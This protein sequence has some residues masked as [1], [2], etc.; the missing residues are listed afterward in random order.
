[1][2]K[3]IPFLFL[4]PILALG[5]VRLK[6]KPAA[7][8]PAADDK[9][10]IDGQTNGVRALD[11]KA[12][13]AKLGNP[14]VSGYVLS[15]TTS[16]V[17]SWVAQSGGAGTWGTITG[18]LS[19]Q[20][21]L[22]TALGLK[23]AAA[24]NLSDLADAATARGNLGLGSL[25]TQSGT[26]SGSH[27]GTSSGTNTGDQTISIT[28]DVTASGSTGALSATV[29]KIN[30][31]TLSGLGTG[32]LKN[33]TGTG[34]PSI[35]VAGD[36]PTLNQNTTGSA[37]TL[38]TGRTIGMTGDVTW[39]SASF[40][41]SGNVTGTSTLGNIPTGTTMAG[42]ILATNIA[43]PGSPAAGKVSIFTDSTDLRFHDKNSAGTVG[44]TV[45]ADT[46]ASNN[47]LTAISAAGVISKA[48]PA[49]SNLSGNIA[50]SQMNSG[51][52]AS[53]STFWR[54][55]GT[56][57][58]P[59]GSGTV[60][61][62]AGSLTASAVMVGNGTTDSKVL[63]S[64]GTTTTVLHGN[65]AGLPT[66]AAVDL[67]NDVTGNLPVSKLNSGTSAS[68]STFWRG[69]G[70]WA[71]PGGSGTVTVVAS[72]SLTSTALVTGGGTTTLQTPSATATLDASGNIST[73][74]SITTGAG[75]SVGGYAA[76]TQGT[77]TTAPATSVGFMAP[78][79]VSTPFMMTLPAAP[80][81]GFLLNTG[82]S[83]PSTISFVASNG[84]GNVLL[85]AGT[86]AIA[87]GKTLTVSN[88]LTLAGTDGTTLTGPGSSTTIGG[89]GISQTWTGVNTFTPDARS[90]GVA[91]YLVVNTPADTG[92]TAAT[93]SIGVD[94][95]TATRTW[96]TTGTV[97]NQREIFFRGKTYAS[98]S[99]SQTFTDISTV[100]ITP[101]IAGT[102]AV[103]T[104]GHSLQI[105]DATSAASSVTGGLVVAAALGT[106]A[107]ST[108]IGN[109]NINTGGTLT[110]GGTQTF[111][112]ATTHN[113]AVTINGAAATTALTITN[114]ARTS[115]VLPYIKY[116]IPTDTGRTASTESPGIQGVTG[117]RT[118]ATTG[119]VALQR[120]IF[121][122]GP[123]YASASASQTFTDV[124]N[125][126]LT[127]PVAGTNAIFTRG[128]TLGIVDST[129]AS[130]SI[131]GGLIV[132]TTLG[133]SATS[134][135]IGG[136]NINAGGTITGGGAF[137]IGTTNS[138]TVGTIELGAAS[139]TTIAR[140]SAGQI[141]VEGVTV[142]T[143]SGTNTLTNK[144]IT[145]RI[146]SIGSGATPTV[147][148]D[149]GDCVNITG[150]AVDITSMTTNLSGTPTEFQQLEY[151]ITGTAARAITWGA[152][153]VAGPTALPT[154]TTTT[155]ALHV[156]FEWDGAL[157]KWVCL[158]AGSDS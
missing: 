44:T 42:S 43:A 158:S 137:S 41:G 148:T 151:R 139:D 24:S 59:G 143:V 111:T 57:A 76:F 104:R 147:N 13:E 120:E 18:T 37:A 130:S 155:K 123:T 6:D 103:F 90:S 22:N 67:A 15:S 54:G 122:P 7:T 52:S 119:T 115:G 73:P 5:Q 133:T 112:G 100:A 58:T 48:Q 71:T 92:Q 79:T 138:A 74:G 40:N 82:T 20:T 70:T 93:E 53:G 94:F 14:G 8:T 31:V 56:W 83:D 86:A 89:L 114:T 28:G 145:P 125:M 10:Y 34:A 11:P 99:A 29:T 36:F 124:F 47:F 156:Y 157:S 135:G 66:W 12:F 35:A 127:P 62:T 101:P 39:T 50:V 64:L 38:T 142:D 85:S 91:S 80:A 132:A 106:T 109:G 96:A 9:I 46:G 49:F 84:S 136:G 2:K 131:T 25:A 72:G 128:H 153:F 121:F 118:W 30:G 98:A 152:S 26:F 1:M 144:R 110:V 45:V 4:V 87:S 97:A 75:G 149:N 117:T 19:S 108:G 51:T 150:L 69:D 88:S 27:S 68:S 32:I 63:A 102:N 23:L 78:A 107:T 21:D 116:T 61:A 113:N 140:V 17:R 3:L 33:T 65:A 141:S 55:D 77:A 126:Y 105:V 154:T 60:T 146:T 95:G 129:S 16:G 81:T 134:V